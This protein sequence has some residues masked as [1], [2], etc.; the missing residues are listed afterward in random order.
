MIS[1]DKETY[2]DNLQV[3]FQRELQGR[4][5][6][7][8][9]DSLALKPLPDLRMNE[10]DPSRLYWSKALFPFDITSNRLMAESLARHGA[11]WSVGSVL[12]NRRIVPKNHE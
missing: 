2:R 3:L 10:D 5:R 1:S 8:A 6:Q 7:P 9:A 11:R 4:L 12:K